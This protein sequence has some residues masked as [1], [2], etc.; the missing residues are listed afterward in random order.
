MKK[1]SVTVNDLMQHDYVYFL[2]EPI[3]RNFHP[4]FRPELMPKQMLHLGVFGGKYMTDCTEEFPQTGLPKRS[5]A[6]SA[7]IRS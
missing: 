6:T 2:V 1:R 3:G 7:T 5:F 4:D